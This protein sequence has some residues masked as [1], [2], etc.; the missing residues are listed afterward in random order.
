MVP[1]KE[2]PDV[3]RVLKDVVRLKPGSWVRLKHTIFKDDLA[4]VESV[5]TAQNQVTLKLIPR[6]DYTRKRGALKGPEDADKN[7]RKRRPAQKLFDT[8]A[9]RSIGGVPTKDRDN[10]YWIFESNR[11]NQRGFLIKMFPMSKLI[12]EGVKPSLTELQKFEESPDGLD[13]ESTAILSKTALDK[14]HNF[15]SGDVVQVSHGELVGIVGV[16][17]S[18]DGEKIKVLPKVEELKV[19][20][21]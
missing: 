3:L 13:S 9:I 10:D 11:Y 7:K 8:D 15:A 5:D 19:S 18:I 17:T 1:I 6:I 16:I 12:T 14:S 4:Q 20:S 2:M 21:S